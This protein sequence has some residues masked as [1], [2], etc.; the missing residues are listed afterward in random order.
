MKLRFLFSL[1]FCMTSFLMVAQDEPVITT[2]E[3]DRDIYPTESSTPW[4]DVY[5]DGIVKKTLVEESLFL[6]YEPLR[7]ADIAW[8]K[9]I[10][11][12]IDTREKMNLPFKYPKKPFF[13]VLRELS[14]NGDIVV[15]KDEEFTEPMTIDEVERT[16]NRID[17][18]TVFDYDT[19]EEKIEIVASEINAEDIKQYRVKEIWFFEEENSVLKCR[20]LG[21][22][23]LKD[24]YDPNTLEYKYTLPLFHVYYPEARKH[25]QKYRVFNDFNDI[26][27]MSWYDVFES[28]FFASYIYKKS[29]ALDLRIE[30]IYLNYERAGIDRL[31]EAEKIKNELFNFEHDLW[32]Y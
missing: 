22:T 18:T 14:A 7:E 11:R 31:L 8:E 32:T 20:I 19:Y 29:N 3:E 24:E 28:R 15:F 6:E 25:F 13:D 5:V 27:P 21:I 16:L 17:T 23:P 1:L 10:W 9:R 4:E 2:E 12:I 26:P 30:D